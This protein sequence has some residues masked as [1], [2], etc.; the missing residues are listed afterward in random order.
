MANQP[1][2]DPSRTAA[3]IPESE[4]PSTLDQPD[5]GQPGG[6][7]LPISG[8]PPISA[9]S[10]PGYRITAVIAAGGMGKVY[11]GHD[12]TLDRE[13]AIKTMLPGASAERFV[14]EA[15]VTAKL[16]H[17]GIPPVHALGTLADG[18]PFLAMKLIRGRTL[19]ELLRERPSPR[20]DLPR[21]VQVFEQ[22]A[23]AVGFAHSRGILH[24]DLKPL[25]V[26][27]G[28]FGEVQ[29]MDWGLAKDTTHAEGA[30]AELTPDADEVA[31]TAAGAVMGTPAYMAPEQARGE[32]VDARA[33]VFA[34]GATLAAILTGQPAFVGSTARE[35]IE[36]AAKA[37]L[38]DVLQRLGSCGA[39]AELVVLARRCLA[40]GAEDRPADAR[41]VADAAA[42]YRAGV[43]ARLRQ[44]ET[45]RAEALVREGEQSKRRRV[46]QRAGGAV[47]AVLLLGIV[48]TTI[49]LV[50]ANAAAEKERIANST[51]QI[52]K[53]KAENLALKEKIARE[54]TEKRLIQIEKGVELFAGM[55]SGINPRAEKQGGDPLYVQL[56]KRA[57]QTVDQLDAEAVGDPLAVARLQTILGNTLRELGNAAKAVEVLEKARA[58]RER[59]L[60]G[61]PPQ[62]AA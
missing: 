37:D 41:A 35:T 26:M 29:V 44:A 28:E 12:L 7:T 25:N 30:A 57:E 13:V 56:R 48:G 17:P 38:A 59:E 34:L 53:T 51:A 6:S 24:R 60:G 20:H 19:A 49:G 11:A 45:E 21:F 32:V 10:I 62:H 18:T 46:V 58:T 22:I 9:P 2:H 47:A 50:R 36:K 3:H 4:S 55:L 61:R 23:Q 43:D 31:H 8:A 15:R 54:Q 27:V 5:T 39:D 40:A 42:A 1:S 52:E 14:T 16:P 33:D